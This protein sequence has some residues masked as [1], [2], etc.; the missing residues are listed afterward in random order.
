M[1]IFMQVTSKMIR[2]IWNYF[3]REYSCPCACGGTAWCF[4]H[5]IILYW[6]L[7]FLLSIMCRAWNQV[8]ISQ[9]FA[10]WPH[11]RPK[12]LYPILFFFPSFLNDEYSVDTIIRLHNFVVSWEFRIR[13]M[14]TWNTRRL[15]LLYDYKNEMVRPADFH[16]SRCVQLSPL[17]MHTWTVQCRPLTP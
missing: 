5:P 1:W 10:I 15:L 11:Q 14:E 4:Y 2:Y 6:P 17:C 12:I 9:W 16:V 13:Q 7:V 8:K 3:M